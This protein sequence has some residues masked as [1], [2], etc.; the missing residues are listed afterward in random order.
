[1]EDVDFKVDITQM[2]EIPSNRYDMFICSHV[3]EHVDDDRKAISELFR[4]LK[5]GGQG[6]LMV[7]I[8]LKLDEIDEDPTITDEA[9]RWRR[10][11]QFDHVRL[12]SKAGFMQ[13]I[14]EA[15]FTLQTH[16]VEYFG[17]DTFRECGIS[18]KSVLYIG[19][20]NV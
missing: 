10:F 17:E 5:P 7:P 18:L 15:G 11:G 6:I 14:Q 2:G 16:G 12:Y 3:L 19:I 9:I 13:R 1:M 20:K 8:V 4:V